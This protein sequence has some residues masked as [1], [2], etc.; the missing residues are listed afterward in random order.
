MKK[1]LS[2]ILAAALCLCLVA[3]GGEPAKD[4]NDAG[5]ADAKTYTV[6][7]CQLLPHPSLDSATQGFKDALKEAFG[8]A[9]TFSEGN[10][11][12]EA[13]NCTTIIDG[14]IAEDVDLIL[15]NA[16]LPLTTAASAT[17]TIPV[18]GTSV[19]DFASALGIT[20]WT[21][22]VG[23]NVSGAS[24]LAPL[25][26]QAEVLHDLFPDAKTVGLLYCSAEANSIYQVENIRKHL[27][28]YGYTCTNYAFNDVNDLASV[29]QTA[30]DG[31]DVIYIPTDNVA[32]ANPETIGNVVLAAG[33]PV[34]S[35]DVSTCGVCGVAT[36]GID[37]YDL[38]YTTGQMAV[39]ILKG[40]ADISTM[41]V[42]SV[43][44]F[45]KVYNP[46]NCAALDIT[47]PE[48]YVSTADL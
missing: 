43:T 23:G 18:L 25:D 39:Q 38:G 2:L 33:V 12:G 46:D 4:N 21:G 7:I 24:D 40:E 36:L 9:V 11:G 20:D 47:P 34:I 14:F 16:T 44:E 35:G 5:N 22:T 8:D 10:A 41:P 17:D 42:Q 29:T 30:C 26:G 3:C 15:G 13:T 37:Y 32:A 28:A 27:E 6:G 19:T 1:L 48:G 31:S 45:T